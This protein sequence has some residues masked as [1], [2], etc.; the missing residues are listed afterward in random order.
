MGE[1]KFLKKED[2]EKPGWQKQTTYKEPGPNEVKD[3]S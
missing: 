1:N 3:Q 2:S